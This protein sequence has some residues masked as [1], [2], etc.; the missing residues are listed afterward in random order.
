MIVE[1]AEG[2]FT[3]IILDV[4][5]ARNPVHLRRLGRGALS[6]QNQ[7]RTVSGHDEAEHGMCR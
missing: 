5:G 4:P 3:T 2:I 6:R 7:R 1:G